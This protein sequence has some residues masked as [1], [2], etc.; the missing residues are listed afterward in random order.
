RKEKPT[1]VTGLKVPIEDRKYVEELVKNL[2]IKEVT[3]SLGN[4]IWIV[5][6]DFTEFG[7]KRAKQLLEDYMPIS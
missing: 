3:F 7:K 4:K 1:R 6:F 2:Y 5:G